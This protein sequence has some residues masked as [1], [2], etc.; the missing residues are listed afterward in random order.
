MIAATTKD[1]PLCHYGHQKPSETCS[2]LTLEMHHT[3][4]KNTPAMPSHQDHYSSL[5]AAATSVMA[6]GDARSRPL[7]SHLSPTV[8][9]PFSPQCDLKWLQTLRVPTEG[10]P[11]REA[12]T[13]KNAKW[14]WEETKKRKGAWGCPR[15][16]TRNK[17]QNKNQ[18]QELLA[19]LRNA[20]DRLRKK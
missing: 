18:G 3:G 12:A 14:Q 20:R 2:Q 6:L 15:V 16:S 4:S 7:F 8:L 17:P 10:R 11:R 9:P 13:A 5:I 1:Q 19:A